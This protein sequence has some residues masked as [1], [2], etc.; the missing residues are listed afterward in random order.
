MPGH[1]E[2]ATFS[3]SKASKEGTVEKLVGVFGVTLGKSCWHSPVCLSKRMSPNRKT[4]FCDQSVCNW[5]K[6]KPAR[7]SLH[8]SRY[9]SSSAFSDVDA[10]HY[11][12]KHP[13]QTTREEVTQFAREKKKRAQ[14]RGYFAGHSPPP[15]KQ[16]MLGICK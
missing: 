8:S 13:M 2:A 4:R 5:Q 14:V 1:S 11:E 9:E 15:S 12:Y 6:E 7:N 10:F 3:T 16:A